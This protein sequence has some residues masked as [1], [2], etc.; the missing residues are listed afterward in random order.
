MDGHRH[1]QA[2]A[3]RAQNSGHEQESF[4]RHVRRIELAPCQQRRR[5]YE[6]KYRQH[7]VHRFQKGPGTQRNGQT[8]E[9]NNEGQKYRIQGCTKQPEQ[10]RYY[11]T[12]HGDRHQGN[13]DVLHRDDRSAQSRT[14][15]R[16]RHDIPDPSHRQNFLLGKN[17]ESQRREC[18]G[19][20]PTGCGQAFLGI[21]RRPPRLAVPQRLV[22]VLGG[23]VED[24]EWTVPVT[25][26]DIVVRT[27][28]NAPV[29]AVRGPSLPPSPSLLDDF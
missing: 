13:E 15:R 24:G 8:T 22:L 2:D 16:E 19:G 11:P 23:A 7:Q 29:G 6:V 14:E 28:R 18:R 26:F 3:N 4:I 27:P 5:H 12:R 9:Y 17:E 20:R 10:V 25:R 21:L 1:G